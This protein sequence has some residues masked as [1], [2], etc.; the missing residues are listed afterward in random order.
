[1]ALEPPCPPIHDDTLRCSALWTADLS[2]DDFVSTVLQPQ[3]AFERGIQLAGASIPE[4]LGRGE[5]LMLSLWWRFDEVLSEND[6]RFVHVVD[7][8]GNLVTQMDGSLNDQ[9]VGGQWSERLDLPLPD[10]LSSG[11]YHVY[12]GWYTYPDGNRLAV[13]TD[14]PDARNGIAYVGTFTVDDS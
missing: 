5:D 6:V 11:V 3:I 7:D 8:A 14:V 13:L 2:A 1:V 12:V 9:A 4:Q 10:D